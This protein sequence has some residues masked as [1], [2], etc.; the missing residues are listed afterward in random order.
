MLIPKIIQYTYNPFIGYFKNT[1]GSIT[2]ILKLGGV[3]H[4]LTKTYNETN[5]LLGVFNKHHGLNYFGLDFQRGIA[6]AYEYSMHIQYP[7]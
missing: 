7:L 4:N 2:Y 5:T 1:L 6:H 3:L